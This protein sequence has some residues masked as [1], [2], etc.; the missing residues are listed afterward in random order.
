MLGNVVYENLEQLSKGKGLNL[1]QGTFNTLISE[2]A[3]YLNLQPFY[4]DIIIKLKKE[5]TVKKPNKEGNVSILDFGV[6]RFNKNKTLTI[7]L[8]LEDFNDFRFLP[9]VLFRE[10]CYCFI[11]K[12]SSHLVKI[13]IKQIVE[14]NL[15]RLSASKEWKKLFRDTLV[16]KEFIN[17]SFD[18]LE[19]IFK[20][21]AKEPIENT[22]QFFFREIRE[23][24]LL[25]YDGNINQICDIFF[26]N[27]TY[28]AS[29]SLFDKD[30]VETLRVLIHLFYENKSYLNLSD[31]KTLFKK[32]KENHQIYSELSLRKFTENYL[33]YEVCLPNSW[34]RSRVYKDFK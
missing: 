30:I 24:P 28:Q 33:H 4:Q 7:T 10:A 23:K 17:A 13:M 25:S 9:F 29:R 14:N 1:L 3:N 20:I 11:F 16:D 19:K 34:S 5:G 2:L 15:S 6:E 26:F 32:F 12:D 21:E 22:V 18:I 27:Y 8:K 31:Y